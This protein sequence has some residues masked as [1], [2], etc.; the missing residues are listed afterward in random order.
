MT[1]LVEQNF[2]L[3][4]RIA[5]SMLEGVAD[6]EGSAIALSAQAD[7]VSAELREAQRRFESAPDD[8]SLHH[9][10]TAARAAFCG[11]V[12]GERLLESFSGRGE[13]GLDEAL[14]TFDPTANA[15]VRYLNERADGDAA[16]MVAA[17]EHA[18]AMLPPERRASL[19]R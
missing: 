1:S 19:S 17:V 4:L 9:R 16:G 3:V 7:Q 10:V 6:P 18:C 13:S 11:Q 8:D 12:A 14:D 15:I 2:T 5:N